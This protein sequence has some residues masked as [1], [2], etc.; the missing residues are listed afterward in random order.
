MHN[1]KWSYHT[2]NSSLHLHSNFMILFFLTAK[3]SVVEDTT[4]LLSIH[5]LMDIPDSERQTVYVF[6]HTWM[7]AL[8]GFWIF[9]NAC[10]FWNT[11]RGYKIS[12]GP[13]EGELSKGMEVMQW[14]KGRRA[15]VEQ[16]MLNGV[17]GSRAS[18]KKK[19][20]EIT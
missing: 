4:F 19:Y 2:Q 12:K 6:C 20:G 18:W 9:N 11:H 5:Q 3:Y 17:G 10:Y 14:Y 1:K 7:L 15:I 16:E 13:W 8:A